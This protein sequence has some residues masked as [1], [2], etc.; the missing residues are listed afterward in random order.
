MLSRALPAIAVAMILATAAATHAAPVNVALGADVT[1]SRAMTPGFPLSH[2]VDGS[3]T[4]GSQVYGEPAAYWFDLHT[5]KTVDT[6]H[7]EGYSSFYLCPE[8]T[9]SGKLASGDGW[10][11]LLHVTGNT[12]VSRT[13]AFAAF[14]GRYFQFSVDDCVYRDPYW[15]EFEL[16]EV[17]EPSTLCLAA[18]GLIGLCSRRRKR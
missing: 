5:P 3:Y 7:F 16:H 18:L 14:R 8:Y 11:E 9:L 17:P 15:M 4:T 12:E 1:S 2:L 13:D 10:T 6:M